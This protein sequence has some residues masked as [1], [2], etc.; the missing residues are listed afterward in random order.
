MRSDSASVSRKEDAVRWVFFLLWLIATLQLSSRVVALQFL[1]HFE[2][3]L[4]SV[5]LFSP[6]LM[7]FSHC[8]CVSSPALV[9]C[10]VFV[11]NSTMLLVLHI[12]HHY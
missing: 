11:H 7:Q 8:E 12:L 3:I 1:S 5:R 9:F 10:V 4:T 6:L 2:A